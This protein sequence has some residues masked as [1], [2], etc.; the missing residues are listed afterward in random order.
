MSEGKR[1][2]KPY[3]EGGNR[4]KGARKR[5]CKKH[6]FVP[7][8]H[9]ALLLMGLEE[10]TANTGATRSGAKPQWYSPGR[11]F[12]GWVTVFP[13]LLGHRR[14]FGPLSKPYSRSGWRQ[15]SA[16]GTFCFAL[17][18]LPN[19]TYAMSTALWLFSQRAIPFKKFVGGG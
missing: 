6:T 11:A 10:Q 3:E 19:R 12:L 5:S 18:L 9:P 1:V 17:Y 4:S 7:S 16:T 15:P 2:P 14:F 8:G 13:N